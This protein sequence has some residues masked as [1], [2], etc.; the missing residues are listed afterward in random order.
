MKLQ[1]NWEKDLKEART[2]V[3]VVIMMGELEMGPRERN[4]AIP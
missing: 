3:E 1:L 4:E 2:E